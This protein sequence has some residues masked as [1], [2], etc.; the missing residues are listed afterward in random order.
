MKAD[1]SGLEEADIPAAILELTSSK[2]QLDAALSAH[3]KAVK[4]SL[5]DFIG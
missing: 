1:L 3:A 2:V 5:F 4:S